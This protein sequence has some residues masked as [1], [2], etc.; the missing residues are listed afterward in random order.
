M[1]LQYYH[2]TIK[3]D[4]AMNLQVG[5]LVPAYLQAYRSKGTA[6][7]HCTSLHMYTGT[8]NEISPSSAVSASINICMWLVQIGEAIGDQ[9][10]MTCHRVL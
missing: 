10:E 3:Q 7:N 2:I 6:L 1:Q 9:T 5:T 8:L 4:L